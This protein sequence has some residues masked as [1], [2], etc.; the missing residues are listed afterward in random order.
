MRSQLGTAP[1]SFPLEENQQTV[2][3][4]STTA[5]SSQPAE[6]PSPST[7]REQVQEKFTEQGLIMSPP[8]QTPTTQM[9]DTPSE[10]GSTDL[11]TPSPAC[12]PQPVKSQ[13]TPNPQPKN[14][15]PVMPIV[16][17]VPVMPLSPKTS[18]QA[19]RDSVSA[20]SSTSQTQLESISEQARR[21]S[22]TSVP[23]M[24]DV[25]PVASTETSK[26]ASPPAPPKSWADLVRSKVAPKTPSGAVTI[27]QIAN[28]LGAAKNE[29]LSDV[30]NTIDATATQNASKIAFLKP[31]G[32]V[33]TGN[34]CY[35]NS[36][37]TLLHI[38]H[39]RG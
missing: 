22:T 1:I 19:H 34:M 39:S 15:K 7:P 21:S 10:M 13:P 14:N 20:V 38:T 8:V 18:R 17:A 29:T 5:E 35:M 12:T 4:V 36:V 31:R 30:L 9:S 3:S 11:T 6:E 26:P 37:G 27:S 33:N 32:L 2:E 23:T 16:P 24:S 25:S 28:G